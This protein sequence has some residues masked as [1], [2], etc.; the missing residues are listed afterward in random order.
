M[1]AS[2]ATLPNPAR[3]RIAF[4]NSIPAG[5]R[6]M[7]CSCRAVNCLIESKSSIPE[8]SYRKV[9]L[10]AKAIPIYRR[11][12][13]IPLKRARFLEAQLGGV[14]Q[15]QNAV[16]SKMLDQAM[17]RCHQNGFLNGRCSSRG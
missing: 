10:H 11:K 1:T 13:M 14:L 4:H 15:S 2:G 17:R 5:L 6:H 9:H 8:I 16:W 7:S 3:M 12:G